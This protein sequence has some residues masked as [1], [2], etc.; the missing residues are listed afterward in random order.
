M[1]RPKTGVVFAMVL[2]PVVFRLA[3]EYNRAVG[4]YV[5]RI[6]IMHIIIIICIEL[7]MSN[8]G[9]RLPPWSSFTGTKYEIYTSARRNLYRRVFVRLHV[10]LS[11][12]GN[13]I[14]K[15]IYLMGNANNEAQYNMTNVTTRL[16]RTHAHTL[17]SAMLSL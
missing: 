13:R 2:V 7:C 11:V 1:P 16:A 8:G 6:Y 17:N 4:G 10:C 3:F 5:E 14:R 15:Y 9:L 12:S